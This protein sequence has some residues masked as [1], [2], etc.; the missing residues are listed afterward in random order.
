MNYLQL[1]VEVCGQDKKFHWESF[2]HPRSNYPVEFAR[3]RQFHRYMKRRKEFLTNFRLRLHNKKDNTY[4]Y[5][6]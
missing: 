4:E 2:K 1:Q 3:R 5:I 6:G